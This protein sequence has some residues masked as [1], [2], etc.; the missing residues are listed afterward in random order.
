MGTFSWLKP[1]AIGLYCEPGQFYIDPISP[2]NY[3]IITHGHADHARAGHQHVLSTVETLAIM[4]IR[5]GTRFAQQQ[6]ALNYQQPI[7]HN[8]VRITLL[9]AGHILGSAQILLEYQNQRAI[10]S[11]DYKRRFDPTCESFLARS[12]DLFVTEA[13]F[14][15]PVF[16]HPPITCEINKLLN[17]LRMFPEH[18]HLVGAY[19]LGKAQR[20]ICTLREIGY[21]R[22]IYLHNALLKLCDLY[23]QCG[24]KL[25]PLLP[26]HQVDK[27]YLRGEIA[28]APPGS[29]QARLTH[30]LPETITAMASGWMNV[31]AKARQRQVELPLIISDHA[32][33]DELN[34]T[35]NEVNAIEVWITH[36]REEALLHA[37]LSRGVNAKALNTVGEY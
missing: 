17:S 24:I 21:E 11:G 14:G 18:C 29:V 22:P 25:G 35:I 2:V 31:T 32:D 6:Q 12:C 5:F 1:T 8:G 7:I 28:I 13:T 36:G 23:E 27:K 30:S 3:A 19:A 33:W 10:I 9:P 4:Q 37:C 34:Q 26:I 20:I 15:L 16:R